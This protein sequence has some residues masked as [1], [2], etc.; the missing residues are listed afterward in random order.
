VTDSAMFFTRQVWRRLHLAIGTHG[1]F[2]GS[3]PV[4]FVKK[5]TEYQ[6]FINGFVGKNGMQGCL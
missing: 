5:I 2:L 6:P 4:S 3:S 1:G